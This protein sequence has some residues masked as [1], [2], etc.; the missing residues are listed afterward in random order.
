MAIVKQMFPGKKKGSK[1]DPQVLEMLRKMDEKRDERVI[2]AYNAKFKK[3][4][5]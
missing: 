4:G 2:K 5:N 3:L 1:A